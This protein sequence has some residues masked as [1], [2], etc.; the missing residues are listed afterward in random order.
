MTA[1]KTTWTLFVPLHAVA[2][3]RLVVSVVEGRST[4]TDACALVAVRT[5][6]VVTAVPFVACA[7]LAPPWVT[8][9]VNGA[10]VNAAPLVIATLT[11]KGS[12][13]QVFGNPF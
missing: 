9:K 13:S 8:A 11:V 12:A 6:N 1:W 5:F 4:N 2:V 10:F 3:M 7:T